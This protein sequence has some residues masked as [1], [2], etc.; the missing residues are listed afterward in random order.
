MIAPKRAGG[1]QV[2]T[3]T[4]LHVFV[5]RR[6]VELDSTQLT[7]EQLITAAGFPSDGHDL[8]RLQ[9]EGDQTGGELIPANGTLLVKNGERFR[10]VPGN[11]T[12]GA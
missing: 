6:K 1:R 12:F 9:G 4:K 8:F 2:A 5:N 7:R 10:I 11:L 3:T